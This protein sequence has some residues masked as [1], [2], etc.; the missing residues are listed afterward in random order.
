MFPLGIVLICL[1]ASG[2]LL[3]AQE[4]M[5]QRIDRLARPF[6]DHEIIKGMTIG[7]IHDGQKYVQGYGVLA[8]ERPTT[9]D[10]DTVYEIGSVS[11]VFTGLLLADA[12]VAQRVQLDQP[13]QELGPDG[14]QLPKYGDEPLTL[15]HLATHTSGL[16]RLAD[17]M[18]FGDANNPYADY[19]PELMHEFLRG[20]KL[21]RAPGKAIEYSN[22][23]AGLLGYVLAHHHGGSYQSLLSERITSPLGMTSTTIELTPQQQSRLAIPH[24]ADGD[25]ASNWDLPTLVGAGG[26]RSTVNDMLA[27]VAANLNPPAGELGKAIEMAWDVHQQPIADSD[28]AVGLGWHVAKDQQTRWHNGETGGYHSMVLVN[29]NI[30]AAVVVLANSASG[31]VDGLAQDI[32]RMLAGQKVEPKKFETTVV[33]PAEVMERYVGRY[34]IVPQFVLT[35]SVNDGKLMVGA[36]GQPTFRVYPRSETEWFYKIVDAT[37][38]FKVGEDGKCQELDLFQN[39]VHQTARRIE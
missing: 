28:F 34:A 37:L 20:H 2:A 31:E 12:V 29:R 27:F 30:P 9:P 17:N 26:I 4:P 23:G 33:V 25:V 22:L 5:A 16:P 21:Q 19:T 8:A 3:P 38:T 14:L 7:V 32:L 10:G 24:N 35:V 18:P 39:G 11:K 1:A 15:L 13:A 6:V 36:T